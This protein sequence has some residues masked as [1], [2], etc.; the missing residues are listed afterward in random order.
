[1]KKIVCSLFI[2]LLVSA[3]AVFAKDDPLILMAEM[4]TGPMGAPIPVT[5]VQSDGQ[6]E[7]FFNANIGLVDIS[8][9]EISGGPVYQT[10]VD[11][12][13]NSDV[14]IDTTPWPSGDYVIVLVMENGIRLSGEFSL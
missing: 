14:V 10:T 2:Y 8:L 1:M 3:S 13:I 5:A 7:I 11:T 6:L 9:K 4:P 12:D